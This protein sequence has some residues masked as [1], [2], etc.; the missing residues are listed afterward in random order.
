MKRLVFILAKILSFGTAIAFSESLD[1][2]PEKAV[3][4]GTILIG[5][6]SVD[7]W[8]TF[9]KATKVQQDIEVKIDI[10]TLLKGDV[11]GD[12]IVS[13]IKAHDL[14]KF[15]PLIGLAELTSE[16]DIV[17]LL[18]RD[19]ESNRYYDIVGWMI[20]PNDRVV[21]SGSGIDGIR[22]SL[23]YSMVAEYRDE[24]RKIVSRGVVK[25]AEVPESQRESVLDTYDRLFKFQIQ[26]ALR[27]FGLPVIS[28]VATDVLS[29]LKTN[30]GYLPNSARILYKNPNVDTLR[31]LLALFDDKSLSPEQ[32][33]H[34][35]HVTGVVINQMQP[36][37]IYSLLGEIEKSNVDALFAK[38]LGRISSSPKVFNPKDI[39]LILQRASSSEVQYAALLCISEMRLPGAPSFPSFAS[40]KE[41]PD[42]T[43]DKWKAY[44]RSQFPSGT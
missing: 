18:K 6:P 1:I 14:D 12:S 32:V 29:E 7:Y 10:I 40:F 25:C 36:K 17:F 24:L 21:K 4:S 42:E 11:S 41:D 2:S 35:V 20:W 16:Q 26:V 39:Y 37:D 34:L 19:G 30:P 22:N 28:G 33:K 13:L 38:A 15:A 3:V 31:A 23:E 5:T 9:N 27:N 8:S 43:L 44:L